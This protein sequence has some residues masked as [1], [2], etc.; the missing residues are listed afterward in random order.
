MEG[1]PFSLYEPTVMFFGFCNAPPTFQAFMN[2]IFLDMVTEQW[3]KIYMDDLGIYTC[4]T[5]TLHHE[6]T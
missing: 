6:R 4:G 2:D 5:F 1:I 3:L